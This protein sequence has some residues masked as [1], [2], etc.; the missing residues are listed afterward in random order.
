M[1]LNNIGQQVE[2]S[3]EFKTE[4]FSI[5]NISTIINILRSKLYSNPIKII[6]QEYISNAIDANIEN[7]KEPTDITINVPNFVEK[8]FI[9]SD[10][11]IGI[12]KERMSDI[13]LKYGNST[14]R[15]TELPKVL[16]S[17]RWVF[18][19]QGL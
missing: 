12:S 4:Q 9:V 13:F 19:E 6:C 16:T 18:C 11:G 1:K 15:D 7:G 8:N 14:K 3:S 2:K 17:I 5:G 10:K